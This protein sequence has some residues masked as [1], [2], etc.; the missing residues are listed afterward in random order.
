M[1]MMDELLLE[2]AHEGFCEWAEHAHDQVVTVTGMAGYP[3]EQSVCLD[4]LADTVEVIVLRGNQFHVE[5]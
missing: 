4:C 5:S 2:E 1:S 3:G